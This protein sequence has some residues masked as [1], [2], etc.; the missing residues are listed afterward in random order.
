MVTDF[1]RAL[2]EKLM[3]I[4]LCAV[5]NVGRRPMNDCAIATGNRPILICC[6]L[7]HARAEKCCKLA[8]DFGEF[9]TDNRSGRLIAAPTFTIATEQQTEL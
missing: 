6:A 5:E 3:F 7:Q 8:L 2:K 1:L 9:V 4:A